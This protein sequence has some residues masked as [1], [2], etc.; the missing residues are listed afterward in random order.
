MSRS[1]VAAVVVLSL[2]AAAIA[3]VAPANLDE[4]VGEAPLG[5]EPVMC[6]QGGDCESTC[7]AVVERARTELPAPTYATSRCELVA[8]ATGGTAAAPAP[9][10]LCFAE[11]QSEP[12]VVL[13]SQNPDPCLV[14][15]RD[16]SCLYHAASLTACDLEK[17]ETSC[18][19]T[20]R[21]LERRHQTDALRKVKVQSRAAACSET[22]C[23]CV[24]D[25]NDTC[26]VDDWVDAYDCRKSNEQILGAF[27]AVVTASR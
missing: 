22:G 26:F 2:A 15:A 3:C 9:S 10:C 12:D 18:E 24:L 25:I 5:V 16:R 27:D 23:H 4:G 20:C 1:V 7:A 11:G 14:Y 8:L 13:S 21:E 6:L 17:P 19:S